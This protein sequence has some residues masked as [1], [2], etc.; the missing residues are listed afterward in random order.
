[1]KK[2]TAQLTPPFLKLFKKTL[3]EAE[4]PQDWKNAR[5]VPTYKKGSKS[6]P[7]NYRPVNWISQVCKIIQIIIKTR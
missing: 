4:I 7:R 2:R 1:L 5:V 6:T 3:E